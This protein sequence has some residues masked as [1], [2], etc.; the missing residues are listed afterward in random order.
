[1]A[2]DV[3]DALYAAL[4]AMKIASGLPRVDAEYDFGPAIASVEDALAARPEPEG[5]R[6][7]AEERSRWR[8]IMIGTPLEGGKV[9]CLVDDTDTLLAEVASLKARLAEAEAQAAKYPAKAVIEGDNIV[10]RVPISAIPVAFEAWPD[11]P[12]NDEADP[13]YR[14]TDAVVF[15]NGIVHYL[16]DESEDGTTR[17][18]RMLDSAMNEALV[19]GEE[20]VEE[21]AAILA[22][23]G[24]DV[25]A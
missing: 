9:H 25:V 17:I 7:T 19:H 5:M 14:V 24:S 20:G 11:A 18:H 8:R 6:T 23:G 10:I 1:M 15:A 13:L 22:R 16:N 21:I 3:T 4:C 2:N 12:R